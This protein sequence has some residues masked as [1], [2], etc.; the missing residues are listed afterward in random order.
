[1]SILTGITSQKGRIHLSVC[2]PV[3]TFLKQTEDTTVFNDKINALA[4][5]IDGEIYRNYRLWPNNYIAYDRLNKSKSYSKFYTEADVVEFDRYVNRELSSLNLNTPENV[6]ILLGIYANPVGNASR[7][8]GARL[9]GCNSDAYSVFLSILFSSFIIHTIP[10]LIPACPLS[11]VIHCHLSYH[12]F[13]HA[14]ILHQQRPGCLI[15]G[16]IHL[17]HHHP[18]AAIY[19]LVIGK[20]HIYHF[21]VLYPAQP[22]HNCR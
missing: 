7:L 20:L 5:G 15:I 2:H 1:M 21:I 18:G 6:E 19:Q 3:N 12:S 4:A 8:L 11:L 22:D 16:Y 14:S 9:L 17:F 13:L 10:G